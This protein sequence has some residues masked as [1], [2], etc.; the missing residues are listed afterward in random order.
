MSSYEKINYSLRPAKNIE[1]KMLCDA[2]SKLG[3]LQSINKYRYI[4]FGSPYFTDFLLFHRRLGIKNL[5]S[6]EK[7]EKNE[8]RFL[9]NKPFS[10]IKMEF[11]DS[12]AILPTLDWNKKLSIV[13]LDYDGKINKNVL[14]DVNTFFFKAEAGSMFLISIN[15]HPDNIKDIADKKLTDKEFRANEL[16]ERVGKEKVPFDL[17]KY[18]L[19]LGDNYK[20]LRDIIN[21]E[22]AETLKK[23]NGGL[24]ANKY[25]YKQI[26]NFIY[27]DGV[28]MLTVGGI[29]YSEKQQAIIDA[30][31]FENLDFVRVG[32]DVFNIQV[33][34]LTFKEISILDTLLPDKIDINTGKLK[35]DKS[36]RV[37]PPELSAKDI[38]NYSRIYKYFPN[39]AEA[40]F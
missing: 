23:R 32:E 21:I 19:S 10:C 7:D 22:I 27:E 20:A 1:R 28:R 5:I 9:F 18:S 3:L 31:E 12:H 6:I 25:L 11:G 2:I 40:N 16:L 14:A 29:L 38:I 17:S 26:F 15:A 34:F 36:E 35:L 24:S 33:P 8:D 30:M 39:F 37:L 13:W 4:G